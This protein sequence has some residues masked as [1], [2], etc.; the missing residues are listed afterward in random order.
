[1]PLENLARFSACLAAT[2][3]FSTPAFACSSCGCNLTSDWL[4]QGLIAQPGTTASIRFDYV[5]QTQLRANHRVVDRSAIVLPTDREIEQSTYNYYTTASIDHVFNPV[6][7]VN[8]QL[9]F[10]SHP[11]RTIAEG[12]TDTSSSTTRGIGD[13]R[14]IGR[15]QGF[16]GAGITGLQ[17]GLKLPTGRFRQ[18]FKSGPITGEAVD[19]GL[20]AGTGTTDV[21]LG[22]YH[23][24][25]LSG[26]FDF[27]LQAQGEIPLNS[28]DFYRPGAAVTLSGGINYTGWKGIVPQLQ[29]NF[30]A[31]GKDRGANAD[32]PNSGGEQLYLAPGVS[33]DL[34]GRLTAFGFVQVP[35]YQRVNGFQLAPKVTLSAGLSYRF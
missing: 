3:M 19:R 18:V 5:P 17:F 21:L 31:A 27:V 32:R 14:I 6:W 22:A 16:G 15:Y 12:T 28:R 30:R 34:S 8:V 2:M 1:M 26:A 29:M 13:L 4:S 25:R 23:F 24:G 35:V 11:H 33:A 9:P 7:A 20:Q 10:V